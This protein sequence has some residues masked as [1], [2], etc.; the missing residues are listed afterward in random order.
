MPPRARSCANSQGHGDPVWSAAYSPDGKRI[1]T[2]SGDQTARIWDAATGEELR[3]LTGHTGSVNSAAYS[4]DGKSIVT[5]SW[6]Q[7]ARIWD[8]ATGKELRELSGHS[9]AVNSAAYSPD[10]KSIVTASGDQTARIWIVGVDDLLAEAQR[11]IQ[12]DPPLL[13]PEERQRYGLE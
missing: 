10:G 6:D 9:G 3:Q 11:L 5:A 2:A 4:P 8:A 13:T 1:V 7:T 12:R